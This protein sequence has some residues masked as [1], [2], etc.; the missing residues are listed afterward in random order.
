[1]R[2]DQAQPNFGQAEPATI[3]DCLWELRGHPVGEMLTRATN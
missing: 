3:N 1:M 2:E